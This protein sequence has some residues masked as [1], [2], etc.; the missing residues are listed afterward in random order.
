MSNFIYRN[1]QFSPFW[2]FFFFAILI[3][4]Y[5]GYLEHSSV[6]LLAPDNVSLPI[7]SLPH[8]Q[9]TSFVVGRIDTGEILASKNS[10]WQAYPASISKL[11]TAM[12]VIDNIPLNTPITVTPY[13]VSTEGEEGGL[14]PNEV[15]SARNLLEVL[16][17]SSSNDAAVAFDQEFIRGGKNLV[18]FMRKKASELHLYNTALFDPTGLDRQGNFTTASDLFKLAKDI[19]TN[20]PLL[21]KIT[22]KEKAVVYSIDERQKH[23]LNNT[24]KLVGKLPYLW[25]GKTGSTP[26]AKDCL[27]T[28]YTFPSTIDDSTIPVAIIVLHSS[29]RFSDT[30]ALYQWTRKLLYEQESINL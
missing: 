16:L 6:S 23:L 21:G 30:K 26:E 22:S 12:V 2:I 10:S 27:L 4:S 9:A 17:I 29:A 13:A 28:I 18:D 25:G 7:I 8:V 20:Y 11:L 3:I 24:D 15:I 5:G 1:N 19:Y 14:K